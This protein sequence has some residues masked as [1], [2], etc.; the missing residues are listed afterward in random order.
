MWGKIIRGKTEEQIK[1]FQEEF[2]EKE[3]KRKQ[4]QKVYQ[5]EYREMCKARKLLKESRNTN[6][7]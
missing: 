6:D 4:W 3:Q 7:I 1:K 5:K 2:N